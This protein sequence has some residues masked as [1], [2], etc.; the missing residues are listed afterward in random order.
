MKNRIILLVS[1]PSSVGLT[2]TNVQSFQSPPSPQSNAV[3]SCLGIVRLRRH[4]KEG[5]KNLWS[6]ATHRSEPSLGIPARPRGEYFYR[7][8]FCVDWRYIVHRESASPTVSFRKYT[9]CLGRNSMTSISKRMIEMPQ[10]YGVPSL[11]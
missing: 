3:G 2:D 6:L 8:A 5:K 9:P 1:C 11:G 10:K 4:A 7:E